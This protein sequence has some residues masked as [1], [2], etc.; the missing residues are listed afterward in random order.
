M[1]NRTRW[2]AFFVTLTVAT[3]VAGAVGF[4]KPHSRHY[5]RSYAQTLM[6]SAAEAI[7][8]RAGTQKVTEALTRSAL[9]IH[10]SGVSAAE[11][12]TAAI[13]LERV[14]RPQDAAILWLAL[15]SLYSSAGYPE[16]ARAAAKQSVRLR[17]SAEALA[18]LAV[19][20]KDQPD[21]Q[22]V[23]IRQLQSRFPQHELSIAWT[24]LDA[25]S[26]LQTDPPAICS[27]AEWVRSRATYARNEDLRIATEIEDLPRKSVE[28]ISKS[29]ATI[30]GHLDSL[31]TMNRMQELAREKGNLGWTAVWD[32][33][34]DRV[35]LPKP[36]DTTEQ[37]VARE[38]VCAF[39]TINPICIAASIASAID[40]ATMNNARLAAEIKSLK[41]RYDQALSII[42]S[43]RRSI[44]DWKSE[45]PLQRLVD[46]R[47]HLL[48]DLQR[49]IKAE[50]YQRYREVGVQPPL[51]IRSVLAVPGDWVK[52]ALAVWKPQ[53]SASGEGRHL[54]GNSWF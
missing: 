30:Q 8:A 35:P 13:V 47:S 4:W 54:K 2:L 32:V 50:A 27:G 36:G 6:L 3:C 25:T 26:S 52:T 16:D 9:S 18:S 23:W 1:S 43:E 49:S 46:Q 28:E 53:T 29:N 12:K 44:E 15:V 37:W 20:Y 5:W 24:C 48:G 19:L 34:V 33:L 51:A 45:R 40:K 10:L 21:E 7:P 38:A 17:G 39:K 14:K 41:E 11:I 31:P 42:D 22:A